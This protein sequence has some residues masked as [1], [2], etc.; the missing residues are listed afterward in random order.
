MV[1]FRLAKNLHTIQVCICICFFPLF[2]VVL[3]IRL[4]I[5]L[6]EMRQTAALN[7][8]AAR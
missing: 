6:I 4:F 2:G 3:V 7:V 1:R 8:S 5:H